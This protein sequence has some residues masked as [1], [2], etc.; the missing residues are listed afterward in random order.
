MGSLGC[1]FQRNVYSKKWFQDLVGLDR[2]SVPGWS[3]IGH[4]IFSLNIYFSAGTSE[5]AMSAGR[6]YAQKYS[7]EI[8]GLSRKS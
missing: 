8:Q 4:L 5:G 2:E 6:V 1:V 7:L 3:R